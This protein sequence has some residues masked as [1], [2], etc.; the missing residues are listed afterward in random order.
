MFV[1]A[2]QALAR[3]IVAEGGDEPQ[4]RAA[5]GLRA[6]VAR[7]PRPAEVDRLVQ[8]YERE[9]EHFTADPEAAQALAGGS[10]ELAAWTAVANVL[11]NLDEF[12]TKG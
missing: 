12:L 10:A 7:E 11:L 4:A 5:F 1:E 6:C 3:R 8:L 9:R 2:A